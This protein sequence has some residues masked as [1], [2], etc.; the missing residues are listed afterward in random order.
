MRIQ[1]KAVTHWGFVAALCTL[2]RLLYFL[3]GKRS[4][5]NH[6]GI[7]QKKMR[8]AWKV[9]IHP[10]YEHSECKFT[11]YVWELQRNRR[12]QMPAERWS[13]WGHAG[14]LR[15]RTPYRDQQTPG[16]PHE[17]AITKGPDSN[18]VKKPHWSDWKML[19]SGTIWCFSQL[20]MLAFFQ[21]LLIPFVFPIY[22]LRELNK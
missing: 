13:G 5:K 20:T 22:W 21:P 2:R 4:L 9:E 16:T 7:I 6:L 1:T 3:R 19:G 11:K 17:D 12:K 8:N 15:Q 10:E 18:T 14:S